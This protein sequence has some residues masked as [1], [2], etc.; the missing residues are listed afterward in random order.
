MEYLKNNLLD[1]F[2]K[3]G[4]TDEKGFLIFLKLFIEAVQRLSEIGIF[5]GDIKPENAALKIKE[6]GLPIIVFCD[7]GFSYSI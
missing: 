3:N 2:N 6:D 7:F 1:F 5:H 4:K